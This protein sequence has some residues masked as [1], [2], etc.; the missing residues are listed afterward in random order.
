MEEWFDGLI[1]SVV[2]PL[3]DSRWLSKSWPLLVIALIPMIS[4]V[5]PILF[6][7]W[8]LSAIRTQIRSDDQ[9]PELEM[10]AFL[11]QGLIL[12]GFTFAYML[13]PPF[14]LWLLSLVTTGWLNL[15]LSL[16]VFVAWVLII[17][18]AYQAGLVRYAVN[19]SWRSLL[20][21]PANVA[22][23]VKHIPQFIMFYMSW[24]VIVFLTGFF[25]HVLFMTFIGIP[26]I[27]IVVLTIY[28]V[29]TAHHLSGMARKI[30]AKT[31]STIEFN[32]SDKLQLEQ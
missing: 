5:A 25:G 19:G 32:Q 9:L 11:K 21:L 16:F 26:L 12:W 27:P 20:N 17:L 23:F 30:V 10:V 6:K 8:R 2:Y 28:H 13:V 14:I 22:F 1:E 24:I 7:G 3:K 29:S 4:F 31:H 15:F 18:P